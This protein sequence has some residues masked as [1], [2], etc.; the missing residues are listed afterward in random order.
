MSVTAP[1]GLDR[2]AIYTPRLRLRACGLYA[3][4]RFESSDALRAA[5]G[6]S[7]PKQS[8]RAGHSDL[9]RRADLTHPV[10]AEPQS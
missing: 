9:E 8:G 6:E 10:V 4:S 1:L 7:V 3:P 2:E 5:P